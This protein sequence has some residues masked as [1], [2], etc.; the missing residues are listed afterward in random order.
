M[1][2]FCIFY[3]PFLFLHS[4]VLLL[5]FCCLTIQFT[6]YLHMVT[7][8]QYITF[9]SCSV[10]LQ[11]WLFSF[12]HS[13]TLACSLYPA[14]CISRKILC[15]FPT[16]NWIFVLRTNTFSSSFVVVVVVFSVAFQLFVGVTIFP[17][18]CQIKYIL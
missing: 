9:C 12:S 4:S 3:L 6:L 8:T 18:E 13:G 14:P 2:F 1:L 17:Y 5:L 16:Q 11:S 10:R 15:M 7:Y